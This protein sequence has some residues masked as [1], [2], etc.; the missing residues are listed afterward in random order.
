MG[1]LRL[2]CTAA[3]AAACALLGAC[4]DLPNDPL[5]KGDIVGRVL[6]A[7]RDIGRV[8][9][10]GAD[11]KRVNLDEDGSFRISS[12]SAGMHDLLV[13][14]SE[15]EAMRVPA[16]VQP[17]GVSEL[18]DLNPWP[19]AFMV[20]NLTTTGSPQ[21]CW[22]E[23]LRTDLD[24]VRAPSGSYQFLVGPLGAGCYDAA[25]KHDGDAFW[26]QSDICLA[27]GEQRSFDVSW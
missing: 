6:R 24:D 19:A 14:A 17:G 16:Q 23:I 2:P 12:V 1:V 7:D 10:M 15:G 22:V 21:E 26:N 8:V 25:M 4:G 20:I 27:A 3:V 13:I 18:G 11:P 5:R 9:A